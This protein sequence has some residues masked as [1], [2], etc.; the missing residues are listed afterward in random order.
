MW[1]LKTISFV[2]TGVLCDICQV[3]ED[4]KIPLTELDKIVHRGAIPWGGVH[5]GTY[6]KH[7]NN[8]DLVECIMSCCEKP[9][10]NKA[11]F[12]QNICYLIACTNS[13]EHA[14]DPMYKAG[15]KYNN[16]YFVDVH[17]IG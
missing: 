14:C 16:T 7:L 17:P 10:C 11:F 3:G 12:H 15:E 13:L 5:A 9:S 4:S 1:L 8:V 6:T 2:I